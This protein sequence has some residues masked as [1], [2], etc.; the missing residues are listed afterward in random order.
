M[1]KKD[2]RKKDI[3]SHH[4]YNYLVLFIKD[5]YPVKRALVNAKDKKNALR[6]ALNRLCRKYPEEDITRARV[7]GVFDNIKKRIVIK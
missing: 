1:T 4:K 2:I 7:A 3:N 5:D 6:I